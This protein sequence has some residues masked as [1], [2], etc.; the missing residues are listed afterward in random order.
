M[1]LYKSLMLRIL[2]LASSSSILALK[3]SF[4][5]FLKCLLTSHLTLFKLSTLLWHGSC[6]HYIYTHCGP[7]YRS[8]YNDSLRAGRSGDRIPRFSAPAQTGP[9]TH[10]ASYMM[11]T[12]TFP[13]V[14]QPGRGFDHPSPSSAQVKKRV[15]I[16][17]V[18]LWAFVARA[19][20]NLTF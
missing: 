12:V 16:P 10:P 8:R 19:S 4:F 20:L 1:P 13:G 3:Y 2:L 6:T 5:L 17:L 7:E 9:G 15:V 18:P 11:C 14:M